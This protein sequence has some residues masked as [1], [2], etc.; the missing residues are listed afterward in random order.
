MAKILTQPTLESLR[1]GDKR[2]EIGALRGP[3][4]SYSDVILRLAPDQLAAE[5][6]YRAIGR[7]IFEFS[8]AALSMLVQLCLS[9]FRSL[10]AGQS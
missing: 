1:P 6:T 4:E 2:R 10:N 8:Q 3:T 7:F 9:L 5:K